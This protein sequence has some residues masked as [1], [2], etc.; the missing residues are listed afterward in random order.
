VAFDTPR[1]LR[2]LGADEASKIMR[3]NDPKAD[4]GLVDITKGKYDVVVETGP[5]YATKRLETADSMT[6]ALQAMPKLGEVAA[7][8][9]VQAQDWP[10]ADILAKRLKKA[11]PPEI[12]NDD[13]DEPTPGQAQAKAQAEQ[14]A[15]QQAQMQQQAAQMAQEQAKLALEE[16]RAKTRQA[17]AQADKAVADAEKAKYSDDWNRSRSTY[18]SDRNYLTGRFDRSTDDLFRLTALGQNAASSSANAA[19]GQGAT[20]SNLLEGIGDTT[21]SNAL[22][23]GAIWSGVFGDLAGTAAGVINGWGKGSTAP[24]SKAQR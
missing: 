5:S 23:Q 17:V 21:A 15:A 19:L 20:E 16:Q 22:A 8:L 14:M 7:D 3:V 2:V 4:G 6:N 13:D 1:T 12:V 11:M 9:Y 24:K 10:N 18:E